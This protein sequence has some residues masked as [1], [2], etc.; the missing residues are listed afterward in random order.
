MKKNFYL[1]AFVTATFCWSGSVF[2]IFFFEPYAGLGYGSL[3]YTDSVTY[4]SSMKSAGY[5]DYDATTTW[6]SNGT[7]VGI[8]TGMSFMRFFLG[9]DYWSQN[10]KSKTYSQVLDAAGT[11]ET[12]KVSG[13]LWAIGP[14]IAIGIP[15]LPLRVYATYYLASKL[16]LNFNDEKDPGGWEHFEGSGPKIGLSWTFLK[17]PFVGLALNFDMSQF[18]YDKYQYRSGGDTWGRKETLPWTS[19]VDYGGGDKITDTMG[20]AKFK[21]YSFSLSVPINI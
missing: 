19:T 10:F 9:L 17:V 12:Y 15:F 16:Y 7:G 1:L 3:K 2:A 11:T 13:K 4:S 20:E 21:V 18:T 6:K 8:K 5:V 14:M